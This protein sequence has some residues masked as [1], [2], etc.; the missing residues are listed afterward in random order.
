MLNLCIDTEFA[1]WMHCLYDA[2]YVKQMDLDW[3]SDI[4]L[5]VFCNFYHCKTQTIHSLSLVLCK[6]FVSIVNSSWI[7]L[8]FFL[9][10]CIS[11]GYFSPL[12]FAGLKL[13]CNLIC[14]NP[15]KQWFALFILWATMEQENG[16]PIKMLHSKS[17]TCWLGN[18]T[19]LYSLL[20]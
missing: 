16:C 7:L 6:W 12:G 19:L 2:N 8:T 10:R 20:I 3:A 4:T 17:R 14:H 5:E 1:W 11:L 18:A 15:I 13:Q 9:I